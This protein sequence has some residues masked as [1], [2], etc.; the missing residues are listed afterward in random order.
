MAKAASHELI[1]LSRQML[2]EAEALAQQG[3]SRR[4]LLRAYHAAYNA[5]CAL[6]NLRGVRAVSQQ[7]AVA[8]LQREFVHVGEVSEED[9]QAFALLT[10]RRAKAERDQYS[11]VSREI[12]EE[13]LLTAR[14]LL[15]NAA[16]AVYEGRAG[17][18]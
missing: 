3:L 6:L 5:V 4:A 12:L 7:S 16:R 8:L 14:D 18:E 2:S 11:R 9:G 15:E 17:S 1:A 13:A 10:Q